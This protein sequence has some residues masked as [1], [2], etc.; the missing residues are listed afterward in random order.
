MAA[1]SRTMIPRLTPTPIPTAVAELEDVFGG[2]PFVVV[3][4]EEPTRC[5]GRLMVKGEII[6]DMCI[7]EGSP[8]Q[9]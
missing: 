7:T 2:G 9:S 3:G 4:T 8:C 1:A 6:A 5:Y